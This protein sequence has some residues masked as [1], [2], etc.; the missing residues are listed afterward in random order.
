MSE[1]ITELE[2]YLVRHGESRSN[3]GQLDPSDFRAF[4]DP[5]LTEKGLRQAQLLGDF[6]SGLELDCLLAS[7]QNRALQTA[8]EVASRQSRARA[9]EAHPL[10]T[11]GRLASKFGEKHFDEI[12][13]AHPYAVPAQG[14]DPTGNFVVTQDEPDDAPTVL[15]AEKALA[16]L[17]ERFRSGEKVMVVAHAMFNTVLLFTAL[18]LSTDGVF[19]FAIANTGVT[20]LV[21][22][23]KGTGLWGCDTHLIYHNCLAHL[24]GEFPDVVF[25]AR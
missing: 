19:D 13:A 4:E 12:A 18:G 20:K 1:P 7:G 6:Y 5:F 11:E 25:T 16:Y 9:V 10:F 14:V 23:Q 17:H 2:L 8:G 22:Y 15:R 21:F 3:A 24:T